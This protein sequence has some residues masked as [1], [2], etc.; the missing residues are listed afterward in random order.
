MEWN[1]FNILVINKAIEIE[2][3]HSKLTPMLRADILL[4]KDEVM[5]GRKSYLST[6]EDIDKYLDSLTD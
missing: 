2:S 5:K 4:V 6:D 1:K 3:Q